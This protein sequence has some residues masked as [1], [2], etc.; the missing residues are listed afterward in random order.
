MCISFLD[1][2]LLTYER[3]LGSCWAEM[4]TKLNDPERVN[5][6]ITVTTELGLP[7]SPGGS[8][9]GLRGYPVKRTFAIPDSGVI[10]THMGCRNRR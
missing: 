5:V 2:A 3:I 1:S 10:T 6:I 8:M 9:R 4:H 7:K